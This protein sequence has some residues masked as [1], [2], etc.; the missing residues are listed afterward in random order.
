MSRCSL[1]S[2]SAAGGN[3]GSGGGGGG[4]GGSGF[5]RGLLGNTG[6]ITMRE[7]SATGNQATG[8]AGGGFNFGARGG[9]GGLGDVR[10]LSFDINGVERLA[11]GHEE[12]VAFLAAE[13]DVGA[14]LRQQDHPDPLAFRRK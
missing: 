3:G 10:P 2:N 1:L 4:D 6:V 8:G 11:G 14:D 7:C 5:G 12:S 9:V 13:T